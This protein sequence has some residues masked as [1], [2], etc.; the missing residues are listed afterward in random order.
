MTGKELQLK[1]NMIEDCGKRL[2]T[3]A[4]ID[5]YQRQKLILQGGKDLTQLMVS[6]TKRQHHSFNAIALH[7]RVISEDMQSQRETQESHGR[8]LQYVVASLNKCMSHLKACPSPAVDPLPRIHYLE[9]EVP[10]EGLL[11]AMC[12]SPSPKAALQQQS[13]QQQLKS[14][15]RKLSIDDQSDVAAR[16]AFVFIN[17][18]IL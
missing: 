2:A 10:V 8:M 14:F 17:L 11:S 4:N 12:R 9:S 18:F 5:S 3:Q 7:Q 1:I 6:S 13:T 15:L 16:D